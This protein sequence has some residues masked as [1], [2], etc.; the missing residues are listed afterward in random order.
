MGALWPSVGTFDTKIARRDFYHKYLQINMINI[1]AT[2][3]RDNYLSNYRKTLHFYG[4]LGPWKSARYCDTSRCRTICYDTLW[5]ALPQGG[6]E[7]A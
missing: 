1:R 4:E 5:R 3:L 2:L 6:I 7:I